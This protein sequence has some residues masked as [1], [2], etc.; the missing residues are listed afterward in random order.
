LDPVGA[1]HAY[2]SL[3]SGTTGQPTLALVDAHGL[4]DFCEW[5]INEI[6]L[7]RSD[8]WFEGSDPSAD[9][10]ITNALLAFTSGACL[11]VPT[12]RQRLRLATLAAM[13]G[14]TIMRVVPSVGSLMLAEAGRR[15]T[16][17]P[18]L[19]VLA[20][21]G[22]ELPVSLPARMLR[23]FHSSARTLNTYGMTESAGFLLFHWFDARQL[24]IDSSV[25][26]VPLGQ[27]TAGVH[28]WID[29]SGQYP[30]TDG[31]LDGIG[32]LVVKAATVAI[33]IETADEPGVVNRKPGAGA[34]GE[35]RTGDLVRE[36]D[37]N[38][39]FLGR[40]GRIVKI[41]GVRINLA[42]LDQLAS[43][44]L[45]RNVCMLKHGGGLV[46]LVESE[47]QV[48]LGELT[49][50]TAGTLHGPLIPGHVITVSKLPRTNSG[51]ISIGECAEIA[52]HAI[53]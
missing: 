16:L 53:G 43:G 20:F 24:P 45:K 44:L 25:G 9:L 26:S 37:D 29:R 41:H 6:D 4:G 38:F 40:I 22:D 34:E 51:K 13:H 5:T 14:T 10:A 17:M 23:A 12:P 47:H 39:I 30:A 48:S 15:Q 19:R 1:S 11:V 32:E 27:P 8:R 31:N 46:A 49:R 3:T 50:Q 2:L 33:E 7:V 28:A 42:Q 21:G 52:R 36:N 18:K 35:L